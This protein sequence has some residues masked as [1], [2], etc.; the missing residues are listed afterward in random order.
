MHGKRALLILPH[1]PDDIIL[2]QETKLFRERFRSTAAISACK[3][4]WN[5][6]L[7]LALPT[8]G[9]MG[10]AGCGVL[11]NIGTGITQVDHRSIN[12]LCEHR[13]LVTWVAAVFK[14]GSH[15]LGISYGY[16]RV[17]R[18]QQS[19]P[20]SYRGRYQNIKGTMD[21]SWRLEP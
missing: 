19:D 7:N 3:L 12:N 10:S 20:R 1:T 2:L 14:G 6:V 13:V 18:E 21:H 11:G 16:R 17:E 5:P 8:Q 9:T 15:H 4:G